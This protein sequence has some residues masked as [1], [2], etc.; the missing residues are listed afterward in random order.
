MRRRPRLGMHAYVTDHPATSVRTAPT[1]RSAD[2]AESARVARSFLLAR[3]EAQGLTVP[4]DG[5]IWCGERRAHGLSAQPRR[6]RPPPSSHSDLATP[7]LALRV[8]TQR[9][10][11]SR[12]FTGMIPHHRLS[13]ATRPEPVIHRTSHPSLAGD[14]SQDYARV[15]LVGGRPEKPPSPLLRGRVVSGPEVSCAEVRRAGPAIAQATWG[16][17]DKGEIAVGSD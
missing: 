11:V 16:S 2:S 5:R 3:S 17:G 10:R 4:P 6:R 12:R 7:A 8:G 9:S 14:G 13:P 1:A 15:G